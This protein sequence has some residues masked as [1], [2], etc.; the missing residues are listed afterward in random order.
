M[1]QQLYAFGNII[2]P[3]ITLTKAEIIKHYRSLKN[4]NEKLVKML[5]AI[6]FFKI[7]K[8]DKGVLFIC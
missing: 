5:C 8:T 3:G 1:V 6:Q 7:G 4:G 2:K